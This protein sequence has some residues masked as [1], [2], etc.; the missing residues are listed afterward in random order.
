MR[1]A[2]RAVIAFL[3]AL[4]S[5]GTVDIRARAG[6]PRSGRRLKRRYETNQPRSTGTVAPV[7][8]RL[9]EA[10]IPG[11][12]LGSVADW[13]VHPVRRPAR[14]ESSFGRF[15]ASSGD[16][17]LPS[18]SE[19]CRWG[20]FLLRRCAATSELREHALERSRRVIGRDG[21]ASARRAAVARLRARRRDRRWTMTPASP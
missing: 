11:R 4:A 8:E 10:L 2:L 5:K 13:R 20:T 7:P 1:L 14:E 19:L 16:G 12:P 3:R 9:R 6:R 21:G 15:P 17:C 18:I